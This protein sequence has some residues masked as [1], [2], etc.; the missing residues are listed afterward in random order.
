[1]TSL[2]A[3]ISACSGLGRRQRSTTPAIQESATPKITPGKPNRAIPPRFESTIERSSLKRPS[4]LIRREP[5]N[6]LGMRGQPAGS[7]PERA[8]SKPDLDFSLPHHFGK[9]ANE[10][11]ELT[12]PPRSREMSV[13]SISHLYLVVALLNASPPVREARSRHP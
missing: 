6:S 5:S 8:R 12:A 2:R 7:E 4:T 3:G 9:K 10:S 13:S 1:M 11:S